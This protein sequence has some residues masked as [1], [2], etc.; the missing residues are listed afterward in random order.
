[1]FSNDF[2]EENFEMLTTS[3]KVL[4]TLYTSELDFDMCVNVLKGLANSFVIGNIIGLELDKE[5]LKTLKDSMQK[6]L[7]N[8]K[9]DLK[10]NK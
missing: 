6:N 4:D 9:N 1:M 7:D 10:E 5:S 2:F 3:V 8:Y